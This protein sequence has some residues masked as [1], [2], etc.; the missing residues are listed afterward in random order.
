MNEEQLSLI[1]RGFDLYILFLWLPNLPILKLIESLKNMIYKLQS[2]KINVEKELLDND[3]VK[4]Y[5]IILH[6]RSNST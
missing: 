6:L 5:N 1:W 3:Q 2:S 4:K